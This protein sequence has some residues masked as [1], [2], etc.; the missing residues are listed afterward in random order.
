MLTQV[1]STRMEFLWFLEEPA[2]WYEPCFGTHV[3]RDREML[4][5]ENVVE[6]SQA[7]GADPNNRDRR[8]LHG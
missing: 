1:L 6:G 4:P 7:L 2:F 8:A 3:F 5:R